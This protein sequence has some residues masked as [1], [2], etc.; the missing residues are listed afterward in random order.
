MTEDRRWLDR[1]RYWRPWDWWLH[2]R[3]RKGAIAA[4]IIDEPGG[5]G[6]PT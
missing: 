1:L 6:Q 5:G 3:D 2:R 4:V